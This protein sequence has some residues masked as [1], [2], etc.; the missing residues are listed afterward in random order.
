MQSSVLTFS[1]TKRDRV[2]SRKPKQELREMIT[3]AR[4]PILGKVTSF[5]KD[6]FPGSDSWVK[7]RN[8]DTS[9]QLPSLSVIF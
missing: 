4:R 8:R 3:K 5:Q 6:C 9:S 1:M 2:G 7:N